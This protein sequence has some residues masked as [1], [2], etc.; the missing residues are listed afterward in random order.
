[1]M[2]GDRARLD[3]ADGRLALTL[4]V[5]FKEYLWQ[6]AGGQAGITA[7]HSPRMVRSVDGVAVASALRLQS[8]SAV[9]GVT[10]QSGP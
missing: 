2:E 5:I 10:G 8:A 3:L 4:N 7:S 6:E 1:M 9:S